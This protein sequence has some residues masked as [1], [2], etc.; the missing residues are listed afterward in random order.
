MTYLK[1]KLKRDSIG[2]K[3]LPIIFLPKLDLNTD[4]IMTENILFTTQPTKTKLQRKTII[5]HLGLI[6]VA[7]PLQ[8]KQSNI[9]EARFARQPQMASKC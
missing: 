3:S 5:G 2:T 4:L 7:V 9:L 6:S 1:R 8:T